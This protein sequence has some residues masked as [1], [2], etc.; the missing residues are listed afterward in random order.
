MSKSTPGPWIVYD[1]SNDGKTNRIEISARGKTVA[2][3]YHSVP[4]KDLSN[5]CLIAAAPDLL[6]ALKRVMP[7]IDCIA[8]VTREEI[9][10]YEAA[11]KMA[12]AAIK[13]ATGQE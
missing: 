13:K 12:D 9:I 3:I 10:E 11:M 6:E 2:H 8:A 7:F 1:D 4:E 5:A